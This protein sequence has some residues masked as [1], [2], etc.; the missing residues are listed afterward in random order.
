MLIVCTALWMLALLMQTGFLHRRDTWAGPFRTEAPDSPVVVLKMGQ[1]RALPELTNTGGD[2]PE[3]PFRSNIAVTVAGERWEAGHTQYAEL[4]GGK[5]RA[6]I[7]WGDRLHLVLPSGLANG[8]QLV[9]TADYTLQPRPWVMSSLTLALALFGA[10]RFRIAVIDG[11]SQGFA[12]RLKAIRRIACIAGAVLAGAALS[13]YAIVIV[14]GWIAGYALPTVALFDVIPAM[15]GLA[16]WEPNA[17]NALFALAGVGAILEWLIRLG[18]SPSTIER[19]R[20]VGTRRGGRLALLFSAVFLTLLFMMSNGGWRGV[21]NPADMN[22]VSIAGLLPHSDAGA[23]FLAA[24]DLSVD[25]RWN[26]VASQRPIAAAIRTGIVALG[27]TLCGEPR[28][29]GGAPGDMCGDSHPW[30]RRNSSASGRRWRSRGSCL[31]S[32][33]PT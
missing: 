5:T 15:R 6:F 3:N 32:N 12:R 14:Y 9:I 19:P 28:G 25:G 16:P 13:A 22:Y 21:I 4:R 30:R 1:S 31:A 26:P 27:G 8:P 2:D 10:L 11:T 24:A 33:A 17:P 18:E 20:T 29:A 23:Y 7:H